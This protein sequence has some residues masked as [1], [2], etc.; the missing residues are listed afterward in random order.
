MS[1]IAR[2]HCCAAGSGLRSVIAGSASGRS[3]VLLR[4]GYDS[5]LALDALAAFARDA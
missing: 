3:G 1:S 4:K 5:E 2:W